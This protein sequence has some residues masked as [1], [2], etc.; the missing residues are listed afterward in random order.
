MKISACI[1]TFNEEDK[2]AD[3]I[4]SVVWADEILVVD[5]ESTDRTRQI[6]ESFGAK[7]IIQKWLGFP[8]QKQFAIDNASFDWIF[9][10]DADERISEELKAEILDLKSL[11]T[12]PP[13]VFAF[14]VFPFICT[15]RFG[16]ADGIRIGRF[17][18]LIAGKEFGRMF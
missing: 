9:S 17:V 16:T 10:L 14:R 2:I 5:S 3:A 7:V 6:A 18:F 13:A 8:K 11:K 4:R 1:I 12:F 15:D